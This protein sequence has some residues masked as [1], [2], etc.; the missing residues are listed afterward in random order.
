[1]RLPFDDNATVNT[2]ADCQ[3]LHADVEVVALAREFEQAECR[4]IDSKP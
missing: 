3:V 2:I 4:M 1:M